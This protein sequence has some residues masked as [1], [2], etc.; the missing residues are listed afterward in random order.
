MIYTNQFEQFW[1]LY[2]KGY[3]RD[4]RGCLQ[5][6]KGNA[7][8]AWAGLTKREKERALR[9]VVLLKKDEFV[10]H[11]GKWIRQNYY[12]PLLENELQKRT[13]NRSG[14]DK[15]KKSQGEDYTKWIKEQSR[16]SLEAFI[17]QM[18]HMKWLV[19]KLRPELEF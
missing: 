6:G 10:P 11:A 8:R 14:Q 2:P 13:L 4:G 12:D 7:A 16:S 17:A 19:E 15:A 1:K 3:R 9:A 5:G 18:P